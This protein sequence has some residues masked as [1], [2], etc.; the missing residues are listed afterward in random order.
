MNEKLL[1]AYE[2]IVEYLKSNTSNEQ[3]IANF[4]GSPARC[5]KALKEMCLSE[6]EIQEALSEI[7]RKVFPLNKEESDKEYNRS[8]PPAAFSGHPQASAS[9]WFADRR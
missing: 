3:E 1:K 2:T 8:A 5:V 4:N 9:V 7:I 6:K